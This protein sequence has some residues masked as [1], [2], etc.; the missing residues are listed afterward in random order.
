MSPKNNRRGIVAMLLAMCFFIAND[1]LLKLASASLPPGQIMAVRGLFA[2]TMALCIVA[3]MGQLGSVRKLGSPFV[4][5]RAGLESGVAFLF[6]TSLAHLPLANI[7][8]ITQSTPILMTLAM[9]MLGLERVR[10]RRWAAIVVGFLGVL[11]VVRP[12]PEGFNVYALLALAAAVLVAGRDLATRFVPAAVPSTVV[13]LSTTSA[14]G[15]A[16]VV[17]GFAEAWQALPLR[18]L[19]YII[20]AAVLVTLG[21]LAVIVAFRETDVSVVAPFRYSVI[22][23]A[24]LSGLV[25]FGELPDPTAFLGIALIVG[26]GVYMIHREQVRQRE[27]ERAEAAA[28]RTR[29]AV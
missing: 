18:E 14:V 4:L 21:N 16:G 28:L 27:A 7:T 9:V 3:G 6:I 17:F 12:G 29:E 2:T 26:S 25:I 13:T 20:G 24:I 19:A 10:W 23:W 22:L 8:A 15:L 11:V 1:S 5:L